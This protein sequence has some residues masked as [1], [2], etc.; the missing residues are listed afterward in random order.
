M[1]NEFITWGAGPQGPNKREAL[2]PYNE[3]IFH[4]KQIL[5]AFVSVCKTLDWMLCNLFNH[6]NKS[7]IRVLSV[8]TLQEKVEFTFVEILE[9]VT[10]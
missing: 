1:K 9:P 3:F 8:V 2:A 10:N 7:G 5:F 4:D 6:A